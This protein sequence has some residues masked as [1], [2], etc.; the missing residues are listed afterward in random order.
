MKYWRWKCQPCGRE[1]TILAGA[2]P[3]ACHLCSGFD[4]LKLGETNS[5]TLPLTVTFAAK[6]TFAIEEALRALDRAFAQLTEFIDADKA[7]RLRESESAMS[8][9]EF[10]RRAQSPRLFD[11]PAKDILDKS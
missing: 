10:H 3:K 11:P 9:D 4:F 8:A 2:V 6:G 1:I 5:K 7:R